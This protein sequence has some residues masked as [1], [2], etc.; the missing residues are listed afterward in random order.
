MLEVVTTLHNTG[1]QTGDFHRKLKPWNS[2]VYVFF[3]EL[4]H[5]WWHRYA[6]DFNNHQD[7]VFY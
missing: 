6:L 1:C 5:Y 3:C 7:S 4:V 2:F